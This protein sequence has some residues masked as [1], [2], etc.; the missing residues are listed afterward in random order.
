MIQ[1]CLKFVT[2]AISIIMILLISGIAFVSC[3]KEKETIKI[4]AILSLTGPGSHV[5]DMKD[6]MLLA[7]DEIN[8]QGGI[9]GRKVELLIEDSKT[10]P[11]EGKK[12]FE[13]L[14]KGSKKPVI[15]ASTHSSIGTAIA[16]YAATHKVVLVGLNTSAPEFVKN[17]SWTY[18]HF[19]TAGEEAKVAHTLI[20]D[21]NIKTLGIPYLD[22][23]YGRSM[24]KAIDLEIAG[25]AI[26]VIKSAFH[27]D[28]TDMMPN[29][30]AMQGLQAV[31]IIGFVKQVQLAIRQL[32]RMNYQGI[33]MTSSGGA[34][35]K[36][37]NM[38]L[39]DGV[40]I[41]API[42]YNQN[43]PFAKAF[44]KKFIKTFKKPL[45]HQAANG[46]D[47]IKIFA[48]LIEGQEV[49][50]QNIKHLF[51]LGFMYSGVLGD[52]ELKPGSQE[53]TFPLHPARIQ[54]QKIVYLRE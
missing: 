42:I 13:R 34:N 11:D 18:R 19:F 26:N 47:F 53:I 48:G 33:I 46:Y 12:A 28:V 1:N 49:S 30:Q 51:E 27:K 25:K 37:T 6:A 16:P 2:L 3:T 41:G 5:V 8:S 36:V 35:P 9:N 21:L 20:R 17:N 45:S 29:L 52:Q 10:N 43:Y 39:A 38:S 7:A 54:D 40:Y 14:E 4:G 15:Y 32:R 44:K 31:F 50:R 23:P 24:V 22:D